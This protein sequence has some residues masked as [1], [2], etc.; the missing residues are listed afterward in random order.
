MGPIVGTMNLFKGQLSRAADLYTV[1]TH[2]RD[3]T[4]HQ[5]LHGDWSQA[6]STMFSTMV[7]IKLG[8][9]RDRVSHLTLGEWINDLAH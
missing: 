6:F 7:L 5:R 8:L 9:E 3:F 1:F 4:N 2:F